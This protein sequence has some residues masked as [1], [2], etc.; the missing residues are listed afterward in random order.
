MAGSV[1]I[2]EGIIKFLYPSMGVIRFTHLGFPFP[3][4]T[5]TFVGCLEIVGGTFLVLGLLTRPLGLIF[6]VEML[7]A[8]LSTKISMYLGHSP[9]PLPSVPPQVGIWAVL[10]DFRSEFA[11]FICCLYVVIT[12]PGPLSLDAK[13]RG[14]EHLTREE[15]LRPPAQKYGGKAA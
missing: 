10:H 6:M 15:A 3:A 13:L 12:G 5:S 8:T 2:W 11:Q 9:L 4:A 14:E 1:F 7:V